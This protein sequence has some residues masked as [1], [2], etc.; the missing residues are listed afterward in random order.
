MS[1]IQPTPADHGPVLEVTEARQAFRGR[2]ALL[3]LVVSTALVV[4][5]LFGVWFTKSG[6]LAKLDANG[7]NSVAPA[8]A[9]DA[10]DPAAKQTDIEKAPGVPGETSPASPVTQTR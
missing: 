6:D 10:P 9:F 8:P 5:A 4:L 1:D 3:I 2:H 7:P